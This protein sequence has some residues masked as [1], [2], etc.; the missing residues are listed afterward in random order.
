MNDQ[1]KVSALEAAALPIPSRANLLRSA[2]KFFK[3][4][5]DRKFRLFHDIELKGES[6]VRALPIAGTILEP[7][8]AA[9]SEAGVATDGTIGGLLD[10]E[11]LVDADVHLLACDCNVGINEIDGDTA[12]LIFHARLQHEH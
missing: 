6:Y 9:L 8:A 3:E 1:V 10:I 11:A 5:P 7:I 12:A 2:M 4:H